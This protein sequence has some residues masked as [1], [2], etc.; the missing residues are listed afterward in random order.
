M[1]RLLAALVGALWFARSASAQP[2][3]AAQPP[4][5]S[6]TP[7]RAAPPK[8]AVP[9]LAFLEYLGS[10]QGDDDEWLAIKEWDQD[11]VPKKD[12]GE[13]KDP[14]PNTARTGHDKNQ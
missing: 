7:P 1:R 2:P 10:W 13:K 8:D 9:D 4:P 3:P 6:A 5:P 12:A 11:N 14:T